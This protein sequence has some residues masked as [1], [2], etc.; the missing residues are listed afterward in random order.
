M[1]CRLMTFGVIIVTTSQTILQLSFLGKAFQSISQ[2]CRRL[3]SI[4][5]LVESCSILLTTCSKT[6]DSVNMVSW[7]LETRQ[8]SRMSPRQATSAQWQLK[9]LRQLVNWMICSQSAKIAVLSFSS[10]LKIVVPA[11]HYILFT[12]NLQQR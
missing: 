10:R 6:Q 7:A 9:L 8:A 1:T 2:T 4:A 12:R 5:P 11:E 3:C